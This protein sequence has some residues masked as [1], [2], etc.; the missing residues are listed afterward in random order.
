M[1][2]SKKQK[3]KVTVLFRTPVMRRTFENMSKDDHLK[4]RIEKAI[5]GIK[6]RPFRYGRPIGKDK[7]PKQYLQEGFDNAFHVRLSREWRLIYSITGLNE[8][9]I[10]GIILDWFDTHKSYER[11]FKY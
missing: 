7:I 5:D 8:I 2:K 9:E 1:K 11:K 10:L 6:Q 4:K 3:K